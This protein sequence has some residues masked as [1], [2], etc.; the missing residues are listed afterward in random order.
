MNAVYLFIE[1]TNLSWVPIRCQAV[2]GP[3]DAVM[4]KVDKTLDLMELKIGAEGHN[5]HHIA[6]RAFG[7]E[8]SLMAV[9][10]TSSFLGA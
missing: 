10:F 1:S 3:R 9:S 5:W 6:P 7:S 8:F 2:I 4:S